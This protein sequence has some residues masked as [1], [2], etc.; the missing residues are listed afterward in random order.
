VP[1]RFP[2]IQKLKGS[3]IMKTT[4]ISKK[5]QASSVHDQ[6]LAT[7]ATSIRFFTSDDRGGEL[8][9]WQHTF[10]HHKKMLVKT[11]VAASHPTLIKVEAILEEFQQLENAASKFH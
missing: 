8:S 10:Q 11:G 2:A 4:V 9:A 6:M 5:V 7:A 3:T 1:G